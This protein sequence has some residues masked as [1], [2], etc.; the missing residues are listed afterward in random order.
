MCED[1]IVVENDYIKLKR[2]A[3]DYAENHADDHDMMHEIAE[4]V[5]CAYKDNLVSFVQY[6][7]IANW[8]VYA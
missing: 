6:L 5:T 4:D 7:D 3:I 2:R 8:L 1:V